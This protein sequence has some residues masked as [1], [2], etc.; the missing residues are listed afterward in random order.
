[1]MD[2]KMYLAST[3]L[4]EDKVITYRLLSRALKVHV[5]VAKE[6]LYDFHQK[7]NAKKPGTIHA[8]YLLSGAKRPE[9]TIPLNGD[10]KKD[11]EDDY[12]LSSP[13]MSSS[14]PQLEEGTGESSVLS[15][16]LV[17]EEDLEEV[18]SQYEDISSIHIYS[19]EPH[20]L[21]DLQVLSD[22]TRELQ[23][24]TADEDPLKTAEQYGTIIN[25]NVKRR[26]ARRPPPAVVAPATSTSKASAPSTSKAQAPAPAVKPKAEPKTQ[27]STAN[28]FF[29]KSKEKSKVTTTAAGSN[30]SSKESTPAPG[31]A[32][33]KKESSSIFKSFAK[34][35][36]KLKREETDSSVVENS[37]M[38]DVDDEDEEETYVPPVQSK[39][40]VESDRKARKEREENLIR[41]MEKAEETEAMEVAEK[42][43]KEVT[44]KEQSVEPEKETA[45]VSGGRRRGR[46]RVMKKKTVKDAEGYLG[47][48]LLVPLP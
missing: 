15:I 21:K 7:Q 33:L 47:M 39:E 38:R 1:M 36:P 42:P 18:R 30:A 13:F 32:T 20:P 37:P 14:M 43:E 25:K 35:K 9:D 26:T 48:S 24:L 22:A 10:A 3:I 2:Y 19:L 27:P 45:V 23:L 44:K 6:M 16:T 11:G 31:P 4:T 28:D 40:I 5:N 34:A 12:M 41:M 29:G 17:R 46:R 8:T